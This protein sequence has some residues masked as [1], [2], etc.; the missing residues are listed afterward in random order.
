MEGDDFSL[1]S[2]LSKLVEAEDGVDE[3]CLRGG[4]TG[5]GVGDELW[6]PPAHPPPTLNSSVSSR[7]LSVFSDDLRCFEELLLEVPHESAVAVVTDG[8]LVDTLVV[9]LGDD[10]RPNPKR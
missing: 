8:F 9:L 10:F 2:V 3:R 7:N 5:G 1:A 4:G 6:P